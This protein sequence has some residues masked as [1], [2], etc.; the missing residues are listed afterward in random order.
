MPEPVRSAAGPETGIQVD[1]RWDE[2]RGPGTPPAPAPVS[3]DREQTPRRPGRGWAVWMLL[4]L[5]ALLALGVGLWPWFNAWL[6]P[7]V[8]NSEEPAYRT[9]L[10]PL[11]FTQ[12]LYFQRHGHY[13]AS[14][15]ALNADGTLIAPDLMT[16]FTDCYGNG[17]SL[18]PTPKA[19]YFLRMLQG[20]GVG[21]E[22]RYRIQAEDPTAGLTQWAATCCADLPGISGDYQY[23]LLADGHFYRH[24]EPLEDDP[25]YRQFLLDAVPDLYLSDGIIDEAWLRRAGWEPCRFEP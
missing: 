15:A 6:H 22:R 4:V 18:V 16:A 2:A 10:R 13:A 1:G 7:R 19:G 12:P 25:Q 21:G 3:I 14:G 8:G 9:V 23:L 11:M 17:D 24:L 20:Q 5:V